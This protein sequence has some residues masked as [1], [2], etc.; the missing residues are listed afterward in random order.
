MKRILSI[1]L[2]TV[3][4]L[5]ALAAC[6]TTPA[7]TTPTP[8]TP[9]PT[10]PAPTTPAL[11]TPVV[12]TP[13]ITTPVVTTLLESTYP[14]IGDSPYT[15]EQLCAWGITPVGSFA[16][17]D[18]FLGVYNGYAVYTCRSSIPGG[19]E[20][21]QR[22]GFSIWTGEAYAVACKDGVV[23]M[24][25]DACSRDVLP[26]EDLETIMFYWYGG[27]TAEDYEAPVFH[28]T[29]V[30]LPDSPY[31][32]LGESP[33]TKEQLREWNIWPEGGNRCLDGYLGT[34]NGYSVYI[35]YAD[36]RG[37]G[38]T[39]IGDMPFWYG[40]MHA[41][42]VDGKQK[43]DLTTAYKT[44]LLSADDIRAIFYYWYGDTFPDSPVAHSY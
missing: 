7:E 2:T 27:K 13:A 18:G 17:E 23:H 14:P 8:T 33:Y 30:T 10:T 35:C 4:L 38:K 44:G 25:M 41:M 12:T 36:I 9:A 16:C 3:L 40:E 26:D 22:H 5:G 24:L 32:P 20:I 28:E 6:G 15:V 11:T 19:S 29:N 34:Y 42:V 1:I 21:K 31:P 37:Y 39:M 43:C